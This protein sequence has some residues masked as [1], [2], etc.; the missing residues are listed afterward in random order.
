M[1]IFVKGDRTRSPNYFSMITATSVSKKGQE[2]DLEGFE[3]SVENIP[4]KHDLFKEVF[5][6]FVTYDDGE[7]D[8]CYIEDQ[9]LFLILH[10]NPGKIRETFEENY[11]F[12]AV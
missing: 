11:C 4:V 3:N 1:S 10:C 7:G 9:C 5:V 12:Q 6:V 2:V 8:Y